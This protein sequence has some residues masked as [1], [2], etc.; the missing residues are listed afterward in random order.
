VNRLT[1]Q[2]LDGQ[3]D[4]T[5]AKEEEEA[6][7]TSHQQPSSSQRESKS[8]KGHV[9]F[10]FTN[11]IDSHPARQRES[12]RGKAHVVFVFI[13]LIGIIHTAKDN[14]REESPCHLCFY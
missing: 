9:V 12:K 6:D 8:G 11:L 7:C 1:R 5:Q 14:Q 10:V 2:L 13:N 4:E 3:H